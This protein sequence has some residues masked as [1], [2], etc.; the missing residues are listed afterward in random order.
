MPH[1]ELRE[2]IVTEEP[3][4]MVERL[5]PG[6]HVFSLVVVDDEG[7]ESEPALARVTVL[8]GG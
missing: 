6:R 7:N 5:E 3:R 4:V 2:P 8:G 1:F